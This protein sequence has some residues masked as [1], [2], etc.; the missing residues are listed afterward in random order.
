[1]SVSFCS[2]HS[3]SVAVDAADFSAGVADFGIAVAEPFRREGVGSEAK[4]QGSTQGKMLSHIDTPSVLLRTNKM[5]AHLKC[6]SNQEEPVAGGLAWN[7][8]AMPGCCV[9]P[10]GEN[11]P[12]VSGSRE[13]VC[14]GSRGATCASMRT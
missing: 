4:S 5:R 11:S 2:R 9:N 14:S 8:D 3:A 10:L 6:P 12:V 13:T 7:C 1:M